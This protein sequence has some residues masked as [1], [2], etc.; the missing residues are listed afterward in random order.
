M[1]N[2]WFSLHTKLRRSLGCIRW[3]KHY[4]HHNDEV[5]VLAADGVSLF[6]H[7]VRRPSSQ[8]VSFVFCNVSDPCYFK[9][10]HKGA[11]VF[12]VTLV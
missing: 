5:V 4:W 2:R 10:L 7:K 6:K 12:L 3:L 1:E 9:Q 8:L 11:L